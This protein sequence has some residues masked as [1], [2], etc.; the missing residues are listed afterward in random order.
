MDSLTAVSMYPFSFHFNL[1][2]TTDFSSRYL[3]SE[4]HPL[5]KFICELRDWLML[6]Q[7][8]QYPSPTPETLLTCS[9]SGLR[10]NLRLW[11][12]YLHA[13]SIFTISEKHFV[14]FYVCFLHF[15]F[16]SYCLSAVLNIKHTVIIRVCILHI[17][18]WCFF[19]SNV[20]LFSITYINEN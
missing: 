1:P 16:H 2:P 18:I 15:C 11:P 5:W 19:H 7:L 12:R 9:F 13:K 6:P 3:H 8:R 17:L 10:Q 4:S 14:H 20:F